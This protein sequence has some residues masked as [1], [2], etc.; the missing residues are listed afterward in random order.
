MGYSLENWST[1]ADN[2][3]NTAD[4]VF[5]RLPT[6]I[7]Y[8]FGE[9]VSEDT[10]HSATSL[11]SLLSSSAKELLAY[12]EMSA[13]SP[14]LCRKMQMDIIAV[15]LAEVYVSDDSCLQKSKILVAKGRELR[16]C[17]MEGLNDCIQCLSEAISTMRP[18]Q[19]I[20]AALNLWLRPDCCLAE[21]HCDMV[22]ENILT[23]LYHV[24]DMLSIKSC[25]EFHSEIYELLIRLFR[26]N[27]VP[28]EECVALL[29]QYR[30]LGH[31][32]CASP[33]CEAFITTLPQHCGEGSKSIDF[34]ARCMNG[35]WQLEVGFC[36]SFSFMFANISRGSC[37]SNGSFQSDIKVDEVKQA[38]SDLISIFL[39]AHLY[40]ELCGRMISK[41]QLIEAFS[42]AKEAHCLRSKLLQEKFRYSVEQQSEIYDEN[43]EIIQKRC[44]NLSTFE[45]YSSVAT[46]VWSPDTI[47]CDLEGCILTPWKV[48]IIHELIGNGSEAETLLWWGKNISGFQGLRLF[49]V[50]FSSILGRL[51]RKQR[52]WDLAEKELQSAKQILADSCTAIACLKCRLL[53]EVTIDLQ[54]GDLFRSRR[55]GNTANVSEKRLCY[56]EDLCKSALDKL[57]CWC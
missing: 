3:F 42:Y 47:L 4:N 6:S 48:G 26:R 54:L 40:H 13:L 12:N 50:A 49:K 7:A 31:A 53:L 55:D 44:Y 18:F 52:L 34:W 51:Y 5:N 38:A 33:V 8:S 2:V 15:L 20:Q 19:D 36:Q 9:A 39:A 29:W 37:R 24:V 22:Y 11:Y 23:V 41:G 28:L 27:N 35:S 21:N 14:R 25:T 30:R 45:I 57:N 1:A 17:G 16:A 43:G 46:T 10:E 56:A 32:L